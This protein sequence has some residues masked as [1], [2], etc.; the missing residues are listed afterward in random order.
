MTRFMTLC[1]Q[2]KLFS[3]KYGEHTEL[4]KM[5]YEALVTMVQN[6]MPGD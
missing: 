1:R 5:E 4:E 2:Q 3:V 6:A